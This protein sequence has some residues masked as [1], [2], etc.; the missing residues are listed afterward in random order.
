MNLPEERPGAGVQEQEGQSSDGGRCAESRS[1][2]VSLREAGGP[3]V[4]VQVQVDW[5]KI[6]LGRGACDPPK[7]GADPPM[8]GVLGSTWGGGG[9]GGGT[10]DEKRKSV[11]KPSVSSTLLNPCLSPRDM[12]TLNPAVAGCQIQSAKVTLCLL[13]ICWVLGLYRQYISLN[14]EPAYPTTIH[15]KP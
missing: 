7:F 9:A 1:I 15:L 6:G 11:R 5:H 4:G 14:F 13:M 12:N 10:A 8:L 3:G 2:G